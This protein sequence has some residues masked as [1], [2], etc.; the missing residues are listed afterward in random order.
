MLQGC[1]SDILG[2]IEMFYNGVAGVIQEGYR[3]NMGSQGVYCIGVYQIYYR[4]F[5][6]VLQW[7]YRSVTEVLEGCQ[8][9]SANQQPDMPWGDSSI[10]G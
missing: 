7:C 1:Y 2:M 5:I 9:T 10:D 3:G 4:D 6:Y 8:G